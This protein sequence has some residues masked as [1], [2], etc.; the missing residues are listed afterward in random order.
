MHVDHVGKVGGG[1]RGV[2]QGFSRQ[3]RKRMIDLASRLPDKIMCHW[4]TLTQRANRDTLGFAAAQRCLAAFRRR[5]L[6]RWPGASAIWR[7]ALQRRGAIHYHLVIFNCP[8]LTEHLVEAWWR[9]LVGQDDE[10]QVCVR[11]IGGPG[12]GRRVLQYIAKYATK[13]EACVGPLDNVTYQAA[14][15]G[16]ALVDTDSGE[17]L[18]DVSTGRWWGVWGHDRLPL[19]V[20]EAFVLAYGDGVWWKRLKRLARHVWDGVPNRLYSGF[21]LYRPGGGHEW[22]RVVYWLT[23]DANLLRPPC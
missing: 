16:G 13:A 23:S 21:T 3:S 11:C 22:L 9:D 20:M 17:V 19:A 1:R 8:G 2:C 12:E 15:A 14:A 7:K 5:L 18:E 4:V 6:R 10:C